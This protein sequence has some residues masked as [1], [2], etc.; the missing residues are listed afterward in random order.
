MNIGDK[1]FELRKKKGLSQEEVADKLNVTRQTISKW[2]TNQSTPDFDKIIP[3]CELYNITSDELLTGK[4]NINSNEY[5]NDSIRRKNAKVVSGCV[6]LYIMSLVVTIINEE[7][8][9]INSSLTGAI[10]LLIVAIS[11]AILVYHFM[12]MPKEEKTV[13]EQK[14]VKLVR[15]I[16]STISIVCCVIYF[17]ISF[18]TMA[19]Y[20][21]WIIW[22]IDGLLCQIVKL[23]FTIKGVDE[24]EK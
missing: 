14:N 6:F 1:L 19:W 18:L 11:T 10:F 17:L 7:I 8:F 22:I 9:N 3:L 16:N 23:I 5:T 13:K 12:S 21:T 4:K 20:I 2:E 24:N 15:E